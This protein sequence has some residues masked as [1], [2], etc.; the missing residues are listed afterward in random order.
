V[1]A[2]PRSDDRDARRIEQ[3][4]D[5]LPDFRGHGPVLMRYRRLR[6]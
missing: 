6:K 4:L 1:E 3:T 2:I 5:R